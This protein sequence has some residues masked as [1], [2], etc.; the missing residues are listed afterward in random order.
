M[1]MIHD[2]NAKQRYW[3]ID[4]VRGIAILLMIFFHIIFDLTYYNIVVLDLTT[5]F[6][7]IFTY[8]VGAMF[9]AIVGISLTLRYNTL[10][11]SHLQTYMQLQFLKRGCV[12]FCCGMLITCATWFFLQGNG[13]I[14]FG[15]L[16]CIGL[17]SILSYPF[18]RSRFS[19]LLLGSICIVLGIMLTQF[20]LDFPWLLWVGFRPNTFYTLDYFPLFPWFGVV[21]I[22]IFFGNTLYP[23][24]IRKKQ[25]KN[26]ETY[27][28]VRW[29]CFLGR[30]S[31][32]IYLLHQILIVGMLMFLKIVNIV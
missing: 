30:H 20:T 8:S 18:L 27:T 16:H 23:E 19:A 4:A 10:K 31:L 32:S 1:K 21:L 17:C 25:I 3:E 26:R 5:I 14:I 2:G 13:T 24:G 12:I 9:L 28:P 15:V 11:K 29:L 22:G 6:W 7:R